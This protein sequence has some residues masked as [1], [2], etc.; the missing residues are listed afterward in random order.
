MNLILKFINLGKTDELKKDD[1][2]I[3][4]I[5]TAKNFYFTKAGKEDKFFK[6]QNTIINAS[7]L[8]TKTNRIIIVFENEYYHFRIRGYISEQKIKVYDQISKIRRL[9]LFK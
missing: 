6:F 8:E 5:G 2:I 7:V 1:L 4:G 3:N 9:L